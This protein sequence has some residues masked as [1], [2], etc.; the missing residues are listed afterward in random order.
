MGLHENGGF[1]LIYYV[2]HRALNVTRPSLSNLETRSCNV[3]GSA[4]LAVG[5]RAHVGFS[6]RLQRLVMGLVRVEGLFSK[7]FVSLAI[8]KL[9]WQGYRPVFSVCHDVAFFLYGVFG[10]GNK[11]R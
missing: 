1:C 4:F 10:Y 3:H 6:M 7:L 9:L 8:V 5:Y 2:P 11:R